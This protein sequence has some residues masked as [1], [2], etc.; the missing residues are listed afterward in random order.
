[1]DIISVPK[2]QFIVNSHTRNPPPSTQLCN[3][4]EELIISNGKFV[5]VRACGEL[6]HWIASC[7]SKLISLKIVDWSTMSYAILREAIFSYPQFFRHLKILH[8]Y[9]ESDCGGNWQDT[10]NYDVCDDGEWR[11]APITPFLQLEELILGDDS[12]WNSISYG[13][14]ED[15]VDILIA[16]NPQ[17]L[18]KL[19]VSAFFRRL[20]L[21]TYFQSCHALEDVRV[22]WDDDTI[23]AYVPHWQNNHKMEIETYHLDKQFCCIS[24]N[25]FEMIGRF[26][27]GL[28]ELFLNE[29]KLTDEGLI[30]FAQAR[31]RKS[32]HLLHMGNCIGLTHRG[33]EAILTTIAVKNL[34]IQVWKDRDIFGFLDEVAP[35]RPDD[36][37][38]AWKIW[39]CLGTYRYA[40][41][42]D[43][44][45]F[46]GNKYI[47][48][49]A[50][51]DYGNDEQSV[52]NVMKQ[53]WWHRYRNMDEFYAHDVLLDSTF[54]DRIKEYRVGKEVSKVKEQVSGWILPSQYQQHTDIYNVRVQQAKLNRSKL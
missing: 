32:L 48:K 42:V 25:S 10:S 53:F 22:K 11:I 20:E 2:Y 24:T 28:N 37:A 38:N 49:D 35:T 4:L 3:V 44:L 40:D 51:E 1:L 16:C 39:K 9:A 30:T 27:I 47:V 34:E 15:A 13:G 43:K 41:Q 18:R 23:A 45:R 21:K 12:K 14:I 5:N 7:C 31:D 33:V 50:L 52:V 54:V 29:V 46:F 17:K 26:S 6:F 8:F 36:L 19:H